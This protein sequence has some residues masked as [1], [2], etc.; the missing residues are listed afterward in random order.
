MRI[1]RADL[2]EQNSQAVYQRMQTERQR[3][4]AEIRAEGSQKSQEIRAK[5]DRDVTVLIAEATERPSRRA[6]RAMRTATASSPKPT[7]RIR[8]SSRSIAR[9]RPMRQG[10][11]PTTRGSCCG[12]IRISSSI[13]AIRAARRHPNR[14]EMR[15]RRTRAGTS[16]GRFPGRARAGVRDRGTDFCGFSRAGKRAVATM[17]ETP[18]PGL[19][20]VGI[21]SAVFGLVVLWLV[22]G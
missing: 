1:R 15:R 17:M 21:A 5:A 6:A 7:A 14:Q 20:V 19:R 22:R 2:P 12:R 18:E 4:A 16:D 9:C 8:T 11:V 3:E 13:S 10:C